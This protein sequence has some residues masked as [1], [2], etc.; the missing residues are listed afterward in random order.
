VPRATA[1]PVRVISQKTSAE[2][3]TM[4]ESVVDD[5][6]GI[7]A[8]VPGYRVAGK[9]G[10]AQAAS[11]D[12]KMSDVVA[13]FVGVAPADHPRIVVSVMLYNPKKNP[14]GGSGAGP[15]FSD[16]MGMALQSLGI[17]PSGTTAQLYPTTWG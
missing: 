8:Q 15:V 3:M 1:A 4:L 10:T 14:W 16:V 7:M 12:G 6:T 2:L 11:A 5:G 9:T 13:S 17:P